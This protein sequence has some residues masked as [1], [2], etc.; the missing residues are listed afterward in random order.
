MKFMYK[1]FLLAV[2]IISLCFFI[3]SIYQIAIGNIGGLQPLFYGF[4]FILYSAFNWADI[5]IFSL[6]W[7][8]LSII[9]WK[10]SNKLYFGLTFCGFWL[11]RSFGETMYSFLQ[12]FHPSIRPWIAYTPRAIMQY[13]PLGQFVLEKYWVVEQI[14][15]QSI[16]VISLLGFSF[17]LIKL[18]KISSKN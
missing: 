1:K 12:Q 17:F 5:F 6:L 15:F 18:C 13:S 16:T 8:L 14:F 3:L 2:V 9:L 10:L 7:I 4:G 11:V